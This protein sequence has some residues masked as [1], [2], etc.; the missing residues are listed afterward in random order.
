MSLQDFQRALS[1]LVM[2]PGLRSRVA[3]A[4]AAGLAGYELSDQEHRRLAALARDP[5]LRTGTVIHRASRLSMLSNTIPRTCRVLGSRGL[6][7][8][9]HAYWSEHPP[10]SMLYVQEARRFADYAFARLAAG[11]F[12]NPFLREVLEMELETLVL[13]RADGAWEPGENREI[14]ERPRLHPFCRVVA[15]R[16]DPDVVIRTLDAGRPLD[17]VAAEERFLLLSAAGGGRVNLRQI[18]VEQ[19]RVLAV[20]DGRRAANE[21][22]ALAGVAQEV[23]RAVVAAGLVV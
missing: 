14:P 1:D 11:T 3:E 21:V 6:K 8:L 16:H 5:G 17:G 23:L 13:S 2:S 19:G 12:A 7:E 4:P 10:Q 22:C 18:P 15:F 9:V 20:C